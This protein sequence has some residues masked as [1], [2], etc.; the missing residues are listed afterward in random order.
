MHA[1]LRRT[2][3]VWT[4]QKSDAN[5]AESAMKLKADIFGGQSG[6][7]PNDIALQASSPFPF[8]LTTKLCKGPIYGKAGGKQTC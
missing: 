4:M 3:S 5:F 1:G 7:G 2:T 8:K 6:V